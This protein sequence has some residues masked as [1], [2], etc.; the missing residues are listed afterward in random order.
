MDNNKITVAV[1]MSGGVDSSV[2]AALMKEKGYNVFGLTIKTWGYDQIPENDTGCCSLDT[3]YRAQMVADQLGIRHY[4]LDFTEKFN[5][6]VIENFV[7]EYMKGRTPN[8]CVLCNKSIKWGSLLEKAQSLGADYLVT[9]H[10]AKIK[11]NTENGRYYIERPADKQKD[12]S[13]FLWALSQTALS[14]T[15]FPLSD[16]NKSEIRKIASTLNLKSAS[17][18][19]SQEICFVPDNDYTKLL[20]IRIPEI[21]NNLN[22]GDV[23]Y[24]GKVVGKHR[25]YPYYTIGQRKGLNIS[26]G[27]PVYVS[28]IDSENNV[29]IIDDEDGLFSTDFYIK[30]V[31]LMYY[32]HFEGEKEVLIKVRYKDTG[33]I[34]T[35]QLLGDNRIKAKLFSPKKSVTPGQSAVFYE[36]DALIGGGIIE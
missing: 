20:E 19:D 11:K 16:Y 30:N 34:G 3:I 25:G 23:I 18:P 5:E 15:L 32:K 6:V 4:T 29:I 24:K 2:S 36:G 26:L 35:I 8:P 31:N 10:Y 14:K 28:K 12:Q 27:K 13:Y 33:T 1:A 21:N 22:G 17:T 9:G 7:S